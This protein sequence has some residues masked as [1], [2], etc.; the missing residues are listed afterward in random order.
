LVDALRLSTLRTTLS[1]RAGEGA[2]SY[3]DRMAIRGGLHNGCDFSRI[4]LR[5][6]R[7]TR[8]TFTL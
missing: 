2:N 7:A 8:P 5:F 3:V 4:A 1:P 6:I